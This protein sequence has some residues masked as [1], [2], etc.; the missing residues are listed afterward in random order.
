MKYLCDPH[1]LPT[2]TCPPD[3]SELSRRS[4]SFSGFATEI[5]LDI[6]DGI[7]APA[8]SWPY[9]DVQWAQL[10]TMAAEGGSLPHAPAVAYEAHLMVQEPR[11]LGELLARVGCMRLLPHVETFP[12]A[13]AAQG[14]FDAWKKAGAR[15]VGLALLIDTPL[16]TIDP[17]IGLC[18]V[19]QV[20]SI[21]RIGA[22]GEAFDERALSRVEEIHAKYPSLMV[23]VDGGVSEANIEALVRAG[24]N[25]LCVGSA[26]S[27]SE[28]PAAAYARIHE[29][30]V[31]GCVPV[32]SELTAA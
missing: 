31:R 9:H 7:F 11:A 12:D 13:D 19:V 4:E 5:Q 27:K 32:N 15:E 26:I 3:L 30:A 23:A 1:I 20:M 14:I 10:E 6:A 18:D 29:R 22:Q 24:A 2:N 8:V 17:F 28:D 16:E 25:R 21:A